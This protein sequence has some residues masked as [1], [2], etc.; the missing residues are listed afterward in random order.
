[1]LVGQ[2]FLEGSRGEFVACL[3]LDI[4]FLPTVLGIP[5]FAAAQLVS[6]SLLLH[7]IL[8]HVFMSKFPSFIKDTCYI[9]FVVV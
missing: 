9:R 3:S 1:M 8:L 2:R 5:W 6:L 4:W 7:G